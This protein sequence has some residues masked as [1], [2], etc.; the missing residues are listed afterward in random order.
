LRSNILLLNG[1]VKIGRFKIAA[2]IFGRH[3]N[4]IQFDGGL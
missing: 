1:F 2:L 4:K 3:I